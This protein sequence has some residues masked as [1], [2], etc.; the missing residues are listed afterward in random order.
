MYTLV[1]NRPYKKK[2]TP[3][4]NTRD[5][6]IRLIHP[7]IKMPIKWFWILLLSIIFVYGIVF[8]IQHTVFKDENYIKKV[9]YTESS[10]S[11]YFN[12]GLYTTISESIKNENFYVASNFKKS[13]ILNGLKNDFPIV[14]NIKIFQ[15]QKFSAAVDVEFYELDMIF[16]L[17][18]RKFGVLGYYDFEIFSGNTIGD[19]AFTI[20]L[21]KYLSGI[22]SIHGLFVETT[23]D[24]LLYDMDI[25]SQGFSGYNRIVYLPGSSMTVVFVGEKRIYLNNKNPLTGQINNYNLLMKYYVDANSLK[26]I[27]LGSLEGDK[28]IVRK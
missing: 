28:I 15:P 8:I 24:K 10:L 26:I 17:G 18:D 21:P 23:P 9:F 16:K 7:V 2:K 22:E 1:K 4:F 5:K 12:S 3:V 6:T 27:D 14:K 20:E 19:G 11:N 13:S 25:I